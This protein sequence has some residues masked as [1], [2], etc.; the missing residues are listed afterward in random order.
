MRPTG[1]G[2]GRAPAR[3]RGGGAL[4]RRSCD[5][6]PS[7]GRASAGRPGVAAGYEEGENREKTCS[8]TKLESETLTLIRAGSVYILLSVVGQ[9]PLQWKYT[10]KRKQHSNIKFK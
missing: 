2:A 9:G 7:R 8:G 6:R 3:K 5:G 10:Q 1:E 4:A